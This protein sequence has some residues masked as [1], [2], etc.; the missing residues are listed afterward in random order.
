MVT[1]DLSHFDEETEVGIIEAKSGLS[2]QEAQKLVRI[3]R[4]LRESGVCEY[5]PTVRGPMMI[6][7]T[8][9]VLH[10][11]VDARN[12]TFRKLCLDILTSETS[13]VGSKTQASKVRE[14]VNKLIDQY[15]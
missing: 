1:L 2:R 3:V 11:V 6:G 10:G 8:L 14:V 4:A 12:E 7:K 9:K 13:R 5:E 15:C